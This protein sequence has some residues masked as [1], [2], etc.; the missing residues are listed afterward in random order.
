[1]FVRVADDGGL[2]LRA[3][4]RASRYCAARAARLPRLRCSRSALAPYCAARASRSQLSRSA[5]ALKTICL[6]KSMQQIIT[7]DTST[8]N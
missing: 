5:L 4:Q 1:M 3:R 8:D 7:N 6:S 2:A